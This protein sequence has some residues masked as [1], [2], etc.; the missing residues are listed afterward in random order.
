MS[1]IKTLDSHLANM[2]AAGE[3][4]ERAM[5]VV[6]ELVENSI[7][8]NAKNI[9]I[10]IKQGGLEEI[11]I[12]DDGDGMNAQ[13]ACMS[14]KRHATSKISDVQ[15][16]WNIHTMGFRGEALPSIASVSHVILNTNDTNEST[17]VEIKYGQ[18]IHAKPY[19]CNQGTQILVKNL[20]QKTPARLKHLKS[21][22]YEFSLISDVIQKFALSRS[23][24]AFLLTHDGKEVFRSNGKNNELE[25]MMNIYGREIAKNAIHLE[26]QD[27]DYEIDGYIIQPSITRASKYYMMIYIN[28]RMV[29]SYRLHKMIQE[30]YAKF[31][32]SDRYPIAVINIKMDA[33]LVDVNVH[34]SKWEVRLSKEKQL[35]QLLKQSIIDAL[36]EK[37]AVPSI[38]RK[39]VETRN[40]QIT[41]SYPT[42]QVESIQSKVVEPQLVQETTPT[43]VSNSDTSMK[44]NDSTMIQQPRIDKI[45][46][47]ILEELI[48][49]TVTNSTILV[50][51][52]KET[53][54]PVVQQETPVQEIKRNALP[55]MQVIG[56][57]HGCYIIA[58]GENGMYIIDQHAAQERYRFEVLQQQLLNKKNDMQDLLVPIRIETTASAITQR[59]EMNVLFNEIGLSLEL[60]GEKSF[61]IR[62]IPTWMTQ[63]EEEKVI[64]DLID[65]YMKDLSCDIEKLRKHTIATMACH[66]VIR[67]NRNLNLA[68]M[69]K[70]ILDLQ[71]CEQPFHC[72]HGRPTFI[73]MTLKQLEKEFLRVK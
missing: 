66:S 51:V 25:V 71:H 39:V 40:E 31:I 55:E 54:V 37:I 2:I 34:P 23:D 56:Q 36:H 67:F 46:A 52:E 44:V 58:Q 30:A 73:Q 10:H 57:I 69:K 27:S 6:K 41:F 53:I 47:P 65:L 60:F 48:T 50:E 68:E 8:A 17:Q 19:A 13:D 61:I 62:S 35:E 5:G 64:T 9:E 70:V 14:F 11:N 7:D 32:P 42:P 1:K 72:P 22:S 59:E 28:Q 29:R 63:V 3:V 18:T 15:D 12:I 20:F 43:Y 16:L 49:P 38:E 21:V 24:I 33:K 4:V 45:E 26:T